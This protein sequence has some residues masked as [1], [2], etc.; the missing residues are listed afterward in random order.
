M[1]SLLV[2][3]VFPGN[4]STVKNILKNSSF[5]QPFAGWNPSAKGGDFALSEDGGF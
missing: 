5:F 4:G 2:I 3:F 1:K